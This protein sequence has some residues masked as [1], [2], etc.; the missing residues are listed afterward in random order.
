MD[1]R[2]R[3]HGMIL[4]TQSVTNAMHMRW[5]APPHD[6]ETG[7]PVVSG[8]PDDATDGKW[9][10]PD[11]DYLGEFFSSHV[12]PVFWRLHGWVDNRIDD[13]FAAHERTHP[14][15]VKSTDHGG[16]KWFAPGAWGAVDNPWS[17]PSAQ[18]HDGP[19]HFDEKVMRDVL[20]V[21]ARPA[22][23]DEPHLAAPALVARHAPTP[24][25]SLLHAFSRP[26]FPGE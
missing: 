6:P 14:G 15:A 20:R 23:E 18:M 21:V 9:L 24:A 7:L 22:S 17:G 8:R 5:S 4:Q 19:P 10:N 25:P 12:N 11:Y 1:S 3:L 26:F 2:F 16:V 13:W